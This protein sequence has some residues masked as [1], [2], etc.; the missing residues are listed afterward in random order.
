[1]Q[2]PNQIFN[3]Q[4]V[5]LRRNAAARRGGDDF[6][7][8]EICDRLADRLH[9][10]SRNFEL[11]L[12]I[13]CHSGQMAQA[14]AGSSKVRQ[15]VQCE[16]AIEMLR[17]SNGLRLV[18]DEEHL[19]FAPASF[20]LVVSAGSL[21][22]VN[23]LPQCLSQIRRLLKPDGLFVAIM[24]GPATLGELRQSFAAAEADSGVIRPHVA[25]FVE[26]R[27][28]GNLLSQAGFALPVADSELLTLT[29]ANPLALLR[30][31]KQ[32][33]EGNALHAQEKGV[34]P[35]ALIPAMCD[36]YVQHFANADGRVRASIEL[37]TLTAWAPHES[38]QKPARRGSGTVHLRDALR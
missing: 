26:V 2:Q 37:V 34:L 13:G 3:R 5:K 1:M 28:A 7:K 11:A 38:Q 6:L 10:V 29:Y 20:D 15:W 27:D 8:R 31:L 24:A 12:D 14:L 22:W 25:P 36:H 21:H 18:A 23:A 17:E 32:M 4:L 16:L 9:D 35:R 33:G 30:D 19:P